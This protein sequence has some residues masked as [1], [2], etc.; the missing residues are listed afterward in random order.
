MNN[1]MK[2][3]NAKNKIVQQ[4]LCTVATRGAY[5]FFDHPLK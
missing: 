4:Q 5:I 2:W 1:M 3:L